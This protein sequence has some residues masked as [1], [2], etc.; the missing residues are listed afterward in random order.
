MWNKHLDDYMEMLSG[1]SLQRGLIFVQDT[2]EVEGSRMSGQLLSLH[3][4]IVVQFEQRKWKNEVVKCLLNSTSL[5]YIID[6]LLI[7]QHS[8]NTLNHFYSNQ[9]SRRSKSNDTT[10][11]LMIKKVA[12]LQLQRPQ[13][14]SA[15]TEAAGGTTVHRITWC[16]D[17]HT[18]TRLPT[19]QQ[20]HFTAAWPSETHVVS[21]ESERVSQWPEHCSWTKCHTPN[22][23][24]C[25][26][27]ARC[28][29]RHCRFDY[30]YVS[31]SFHFLV[32]AGTSYL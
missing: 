8:N 20:V 10:A 16:T 15:T 21:R 14:S 7:V 17:T 6:I 9:I 24:G 19:W 11:V 22:P 5:N 2:R 26:M 1:C 29:Q 23:G 12:V 4:S 32:S 18:H 28:C 30:I 3:F 25:R 27:C 31:V 13:Q